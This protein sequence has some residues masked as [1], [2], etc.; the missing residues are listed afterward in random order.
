MLQ[1]P[2]KYEAHIY[3]YIYIYIHI[4]IIYTHIHIHR[5]VCVRIYIDTHVYVYTYVYMIY[6]Y[7]CMYTCVWFSGLQRDQAEQALAVWKSPKYGQQ[8]SYFGHPQSSRCQ[9][10]F[11]SNWS[12]KIMWFHT[13][14]YDLDWVFGLVTLA[15]Q[16]SR[17]HC[18]MMTM[19]FREDPDD[20]GSQWSTEVPLN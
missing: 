18:S 12:G 3:I 10:E 13:K 5:Y 9:E 2:G 1:K 15:A 19:Q 16:L 4:V 20:S 6:I 8:Y 17:R 7:M 11:H 14:G